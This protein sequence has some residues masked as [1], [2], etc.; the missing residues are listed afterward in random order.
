MERLLERY[1][2]TLAFEYDHLASWTQQRWLREHIE[3]PWPRIGTADRRALLHD[4]VC[5]G[6]P[7][8]ARQAP[9]T[10]ST[11]DL[12]AGVGRACRCRA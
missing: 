6:A 9:L 11:G 5:A 1:T 3:G 12:A 10:G 2:G 8:P 7:I 4:L